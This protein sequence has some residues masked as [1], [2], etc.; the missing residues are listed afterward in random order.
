MLR[1]RLIALG[2]FILSLV[3][4]SLVGGAATYG[5]FFFVL[6]VPAVSLIYSI[7]VFIRFK[8]Y[9]RLDVSSPVAGTPAAYYFTLRNED[10][11]AH[12]SIKVGFYTDFSDISGIDSDTEYELLPD[13]GISRE[14]M[15]ICRYRGDYEVGIRTVTIT[16]YLRLFSIR[17][18]NREKLRVTV[19]PRLEILKT[20][21]GLDEVL[22]AARDAQAEK[23]DPDVLVRDYL[24]GDDIRRINWKAMAKTGKPMIRKYIGESTPDISI[25]MDPHRYSDEPAIYLPIENKMI[26]ALLAISYYSLSKGIT[27]GVY[28]YDS[29]LKVYALSSTDSF[30]DFY[31]G[32]SAYHFV[33][34]TQGE[35][36]ARILGEQTGVTSAAYVFILHEWSDEAR[37]YA[38]QLDAYHIP[39]MVYLISDSD[40]MP[41]TTELK[42]VRFVHIGCE[43]RL[44]EVLI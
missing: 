10:K 19:L 44:N 12:S 28:T 16:D 1:N 18:K 39:V 3:A 26:E 15:L 42:S 35:M 21:S 41:D 14:T 17:F 31:A 37:A 27:A 40:V 43:D 36:Y 11:F 4:I 5:F 25:I 20:V 32:I 29:R 8:V 38:G 33:E 7:I 9:Q 13:T 34:N 24:P 30:E 23:N 2:A 6:I 22:L